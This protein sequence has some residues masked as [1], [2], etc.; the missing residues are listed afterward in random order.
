MSPRFVVHRHDAT[1]LHWD[2]RLER[3]GVLKSWAIPK[4]PPVS[5]G[6][7]R[8]AVAVDDHELDYADFEGTIPEGEYGAGEVSI[9]DRGTYELISEHDR[10]MKLSF[11]GRRLKGAYALVPLEGRNWLFFKSGGG[12]DET[13]TVK[14]KGAAE[15]R[16]SA[17]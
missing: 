10:R 7:R 13:V 14:R 3:A 11:S 5:P 9:W 2:L 15:R 1:H 16:A 12:H 17:R 8:L 6:I 4:E